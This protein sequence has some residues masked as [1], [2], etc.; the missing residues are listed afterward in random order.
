LNTNLS[1]VLLKMY[2]YRS[3]H[4]T[5]KANDSNKLK[6]KSRSSPPSPPVSLSNPST[7]EVLQKPHPL[8][9][10]GQPNFL[11]LILLDIF[12]F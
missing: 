3:L 9:H 7:N 6:N 10:I 5:L 2:V 8:P 1:F 4:S 11:S 12:T